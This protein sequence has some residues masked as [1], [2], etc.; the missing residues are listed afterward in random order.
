MAWICLA[1]A[2]CFEIPPSGT[3]RITLAPNEAKACEALEL[4]A[5][6]GFNISFE[7]TMGWSY[8][9]KTQKM[10]WDKLVLTKA[11]PFS[12]GTFIDIGLE[13][14]KQEEEKEGKSVF[15]LAQMPEL[16]E[17]N[18]PSVNGEGVLVL[19]EFL[20][21]IKTYPNTLSNALLE[22]RPQTQATPSSS[23]SDF[24]NPHGSRVGSDEESGGS[25][26]DSGGASA[27]YQRRKKR[28]RTKRKV[29]KKGT[30]KKARRRR[31]TRRRKRRRKRRTKRR[32]RNN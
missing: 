13:F 23:V 30:K 15:S 11:G 10:E 24:R 9:E 5:H 25:G 20:K 7:Y 21:I 4:E 16:L 6:T 29:R 19:H 32:T 2:N 22:L 1:H 18:F 26:G 12:D 8:V 17:E 3:I 28:S 31:R 14:S 27:K